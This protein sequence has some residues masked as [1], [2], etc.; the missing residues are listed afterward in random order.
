MA[1]VMAGDSLIYLAFGHS[2]AQD[3]NPY[4]VA[5][6]D[7]LVGY[8]SLTHPTFLSRQRIN[9]RS[10]EERQVVRFSGCD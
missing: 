5:F 1:I 8:A 2:A 4:C 7:G 3:R 10:D 9:Q 6:G